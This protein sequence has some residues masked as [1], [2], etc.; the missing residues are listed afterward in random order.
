MDGVSVTI[1]DGVTTANA[2]GADLGNVVITNA[3]PQFQIGSFAGE[4]ESINISSVEAADLGLNT[5]QTNNSG[6]TSL[7]TINVISAAKASD[8]LQVIDAA[9]SEVSNARGDLGSFQANTLEAT[10]AKM[11]VELKNLQEAESQIRDTDFETEIAEFT[12]AQ[13]RQQVATAVLSSANQQP[14][15]ILSLLR[16]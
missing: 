12:A 11:R 6:F 13:I 16:G 8:A 2:A 3:G 5:T 1:A 4:N 9:I 14:Q 15:M 7:S 10:Q